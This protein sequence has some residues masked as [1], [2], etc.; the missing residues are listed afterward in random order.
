MNHLEKNQD[1]KSWVTPVI[2]QI[3]EFDVHENVVAT[4]IVIYGSNPDEA[5]RP[6]ED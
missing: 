3:T 2:K 4:S 5:N 1:K 6:I